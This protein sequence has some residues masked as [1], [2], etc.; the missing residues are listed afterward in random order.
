MAA[1][2]ITIV[3]VS[4]YTLSN[5]EGVNTSEV[6]FKVDQDIVDWSAYATLEARSAALSSGMRTSSWG[7][8]PVYPADYLFCSNIL[9]PSYRLVSANVEIHFTINS[10][11]FTQEDGIYLIEISA[12]GA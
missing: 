6:T 11:D 3:N 9:F 4:R 7:P 12:V 10:T 5:I 1:P 8:M 2:I